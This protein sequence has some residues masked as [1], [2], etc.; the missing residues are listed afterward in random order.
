[1]PDFAWRRRLRRRLLEWFR[2]NAR[3]MPWRPSPGLYGTW[4]SEIMLQ[5]TQVA[6]VIPFFERFMARFPTVG[7]LATADE[8][9]VLRF[10]EGLGYYRRARQL[11]AAARILAADHAGQFPSSIEQVRKLPGVGRYT[12]GAILSIA[13]DQR[14]AIL[15]SNTVRLLSR[16]IALREDVTSSGAQRHL[17][18]LA[19]ILL[20]R[21]NVGDFNQAMMELGSTVCTVRQPACDRCPLAALCAT[22]AQQ[23]QDR[24]PLAK[25]KTRYVP[26]REAAVVIRCGGR[27]LLRQ[28]GPGERW[29]GLWD[30]PR[31]E[32]SA[33]RGA[34]IARELAAKVVDAT[35]ITIAMPRQFATFKHG[36]T[37]HRIT[38]FCFET[39]CARA[40]GATRYPTTW[41][42]PDDLPTY[43]MNVTG[44]KI[45]QSIPN[46]ACG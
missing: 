32:L 37:R 14:H 10:W 1:M 39:T 42:A 29:T 34:A 17:W 13:L 8:Q 9:E 3:A 45:S 40:A 4:I 18:A 24:I 5:Q 38:L 35:G 28:Y 20:P 26:V 43:P 12:A 41:V 16:L 27:V 36:V 6:T 22:N 2:R 44:R 46:A 23:L 31:F 19:G 11:H 30:F 25:R 33:T 15:E 21:K 7:H